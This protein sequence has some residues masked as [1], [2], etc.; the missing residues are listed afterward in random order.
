MKNKVIWTEGMFLQPQHFQQ[1]D[2]Y[3]EGLINGRCLGL[4]AYDRGFYSLKIDDSLLKIG[5]FALVE[6]RG[7]FQDGTPF[8]L[9]EDDDLPLPLDIPEDTRNEIIY[10]S[11]PLRRSGAGESDSKANADS[12]ARY[13][14]DE[15]EIKDSNYGADK[16]A[17]LQIGRLK[18]RLMRQSDERSGYTNLGVARIVEVLADQNVIV[19]NQYI[20][21][22]LNCIAI[23]QLNSFLRELHGMLNTRG[24]AL[25]G[26]I[27]TAG[28]GGVAEIADFLL[29]QV[30]NRYQALFEHYANM[31]GLHP[32]AF[33]RTAI[34][35][36]AEL[37]TFFR[38]GKRAD[39]L[40]GYNHDDLHATFAPLMAALRELL[41][42]VHEPN[43][44]K[45]GL[46][47]PKF[48][49][50]AAKRPDVNL[51]HN[52]VF[53]LAVNAQIPA[54]TLRGQFPQQVKI[55]PVEMIQQLVNSA[56]PGIA[57]QALPVAPRQIPFHVDFTYFQL[58]KKD[59]LWEKMATS[60]GFAIHVGGKFPGLKME[61]W[62][63]RQG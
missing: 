24:E 29:L 25:A 47:K 35:L 43:A 46:S 48:G 55:G 10:L 44:V 53:I 14:I 36:A 28:H 31:S 58:N 57:L 22:N 34:Q 5:K 21:A 20:P 27:S 37:A 45:I 56:L 30:V 33:Y 26:R 11:L 50:Y 6:C 12:L 62:A 8:N 1:H 23:S 9:P 54:E 13:R 38:P 18:V 42:K 39:H 40:T 49:I 59:P 41:G 17:P 7:I 16:E 4:K 19:D 2:R 61:F 15:R 63:I 60:G 3:V 51:L 32:E 52:A